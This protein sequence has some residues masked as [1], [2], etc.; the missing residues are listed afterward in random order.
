VT[1]K[2]RFGGHKGYLTVGM[3]DDGRPGEIFVK[4]AKEGSTLSGLLDA[5]AVTTSVALQHGV[6]LSALTAQW[7]HT[8]FDPAGP[9]GNPDVPLATSLT[10]YLA[11]WLDQRFG[12]ASEP[13]SAS[14]GVD[15]ATG[16]DA[17]VSQV[18]CAACGAVMVRAGACHTCPSCGS[19]GGCG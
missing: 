12:Q 8:R 10:D 11:A 17:T 6:P 16:L 5:L 18:I 14:V 4:I 3:Y 13:A 9:T 15:L 19:S 7:R 1:H 2:F